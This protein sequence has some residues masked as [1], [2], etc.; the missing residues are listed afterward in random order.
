M[1]KEHSLLAYCTGIKFYRENFF[2]PIYQHFSF[3]F[4]YCLF[5]SQMFPIFGSWFESL[6][7][8]LLQTYRFLPSKSSA[9]KETRLWDWR[10]CILRIDHC[11]KLCSH[12]EKS[13]F[14]SPTLCLTPF[15]KLPL[16]PST[17][18]WVS[19]LPHLHFLPTEERIPADQQPPPSTTSVPPEG[20]P[21]PVPTPP[22]NKHPLTL[23]QRS[24]PVLTPWDLPLIPTPCPSNNQQTFQENL[25]IPSGHSWILLLTVEIQ[26]FWHIILP[27]EE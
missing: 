8:S 10:W 9:L 3:T 12:P 16:S 17:L 11:L 24:A 23:F 21:T 20:P 13:H 27:I 25:G 14:K 7:A 18:W 1:S 22:Q 15:W 2:G 26:G 5:I 6:T 19:P 4:L